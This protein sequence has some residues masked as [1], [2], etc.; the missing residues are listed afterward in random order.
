MTRTRKA[1]AIVTLGMALVFGCVKLPAQYGGENALAR[2]IE[3]TWLLEVTLRQCDTGAE[4]PNST[5]PALRYPTARAAATAALPMR[6]GS[7]ALTATDGASS[8][9]F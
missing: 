8:T 1:T 3:A 4:I 6:S 2:R 5:V 7:S 9:S